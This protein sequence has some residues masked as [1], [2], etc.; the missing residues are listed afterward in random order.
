MQRLGFFDPRNAFH[1]GLLILGVL[2]AGPT[3]ASALF[4]YQADPDPTTVGFT[5]FGCCASST[6]APIGN[7]L[8]LPAWSVTGLSQASQY[9]YQTPGLSNSQQAMIAS[10]GF[11]LTMVARAIQNIAPTWSAASQIARSRRKCH[12]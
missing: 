1:A 8:G 6:A 7:D 4:E 10:D 9:G 2:L 3:K 12:L 11:T 5:V